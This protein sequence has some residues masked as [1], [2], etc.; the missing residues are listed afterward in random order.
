V[1]ARGNAG[2]IAKLLNANAPEWWRAE[3][4]EG[5]AGGLRSRGTKLAP[6]PALLRLFG[7]E[8]A[9]VRQAALRL[10]EI[11]GLPAGSEA[12]LA[13]AAAT[14][15]DRKQPGDRRGDAVALLALSPSPQP[16][17]FYQKLVEPSEPEEVQLAAVRSMG[18]RPGTEPATYLLAHWRSLTPAIRSEAGNAL[19]M[20]PERFTLLLGAIEKGDLQPWSLSARQRV[21]MQMHRDPALRERA[22]ALLVAKAGD[23]EKILSRYVA[24]AEKS[25]GDPAKG[26]PIFENI[27][28]KCHSMDGVGADMGPDLATVRNRTAGALLT[29]IL[30]PSRSIAQMYEAYVV[31]TVRSGTMEGV[32]GEQTPATITLVHEQKKKDVIPR[33]EIKQMYVSNLSAMPEDLDKEITPDQ[34][35]HLIAYLKKPIN[36]H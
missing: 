2:E 18:K 20:D 21:Q 10:M 36:A 6:Q 17:Q 33:A 3:A 5:A 23:R 35:A 12:A 19:I 13:K 11:S 7:D 27:C 28:A 16:L 34:M 30:I 14:A 24:V 4:L 22:R 31:E 8:A 25:D 26:R 1:G 32:I 9:S 29:D 15:V